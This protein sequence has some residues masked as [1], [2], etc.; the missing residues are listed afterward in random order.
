MSGMPSHASQG[1][2]A[3]ELKIYRSG[4]LIRTVMPGGTMYSIM[5]LKQHTSFMVMRNGMCMQ[6]TVQGQENPFAQTQNAAVERSSAGTA[7]VEGHPCK[8][9][10]LT[11]T[12]HS[13]PRAGQAIK[14]RVWEAQDLKGFPIKVET[15]TSHGLITME[16]KDVSLA[17]PAA[18]LFAHPDNCQQMPAMPGGAPH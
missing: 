11:I 5:D 4:D 16:Y 13:G 1:A 2:G 17:E 3:G 6:T 14:M 9:E 8:V 12:P 10:N 15:Q 7:V 18:S